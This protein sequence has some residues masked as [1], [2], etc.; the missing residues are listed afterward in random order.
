MVSRNNIGQQRAVIA[1][2]N[3][4]FSSMGMKWYYNYKNAGQKWIM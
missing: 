4:E 3:Y 1:C 2:R